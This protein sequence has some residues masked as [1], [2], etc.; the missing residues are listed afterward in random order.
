[1]G[2]KTQILNVSI[3]C[4]AFSILR[5]QIMSVETESKTRRYC[6]LAFGAEHLGVSERTLRRFIASGKLSGYKVGD[7]LIRLDFLEVMN[8]ATPIHT[9]EKIAG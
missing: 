8:F 7:R 1:M 3:S 6:S 9:S 2:A 5:G 4:L